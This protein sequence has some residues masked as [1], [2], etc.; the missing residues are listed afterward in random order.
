MSIGREHGPLPGPRSAGTRPSASPEIDARAT[1]RLLLARELQTSASSMSQP[2]AAAATARLLL[3]RR[4]WWPR[5]VDRLRLRAGLASHLT[6]VRSLTRARRDSLSTVVAGTPR[7]LV[8]VDEFPFAGA[9]DEPD[10]YC[11]GFRTFDAIMAEAGVPYLLAVTPRVA[12]D[13]LTPG[14][15]AERA[16]TDAEAEILARLPRDRVAFG[17]HGFDH[18]TRT[19]DPRRRS[20]FA[21]LGDVALGAR[22]DEAHALLGPLGIDPQV[23]VPPYNHFDAAQY[24]ELA[25][26][27]DVVCGGP[28]TVRELGLQA[29]PVVVAGA[30]LLPSYPPVYGDAE[31]LRAGVWQLCAAGV[32]LW[33]PLVIHWEWELAGG[34][35]NLRRLLEDAGPLVE[36]W[37]TFLAE[38]RWS[39]D[40]DT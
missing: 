36:P 21:G 1:A 20:E 33:V 16:L 24:A 17:L 11:D 29:G 38:L 4:R 9:Y 30:A 37:D 39:R 13:Y 12:R 32:D 3:A 31:Q 34:F 5:A 40:G 27:Y 14:G 18:R 22:L 8:R 28:E 7:L 23:V 10:R 35:A 6:A 26:R 2:S 25:R 19:H 15:A